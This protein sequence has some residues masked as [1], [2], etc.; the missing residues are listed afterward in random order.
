MG[1]SVSDSLA[2][3]MSIMFAPRLA[4]ANALGGN[5]SDFLSSSE[6]SESIIGFLARFEGDLGSGV[7]NSLAFVLLTFITIIPYLNC[8]DTLGNGEYDLLSSS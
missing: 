2:F 8:T 7:S 6:D 5:E 1:D 3:V 4:L